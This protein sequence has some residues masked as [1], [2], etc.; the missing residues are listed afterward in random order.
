MNTLS[1]QVYQDNEWAR[2]WEIIVK[3]FET[4]DKLK[5]QF[6]QLDVTYLRE[7]Q[8]NILILNLEKYA[9]SLQNYI[10]QKYSRD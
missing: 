2:D 9:F 8:Q 4:I 6:K 3:I 5:S 10:I 1:M 7:I